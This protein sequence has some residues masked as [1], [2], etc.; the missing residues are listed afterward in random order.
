MGKQE[1]I[2]KITIKK[3]FS[4]LP[5][6]DVELAFEKFNKDIYSEEEKIKLTRDLLR[7]VFS[8]FTSKKLLNLKD[9]GS[10]WILKKHISTRER[11]PYSQD[12]YRRILKNLDKISVID[13][14]AGV[15]GFSYNFFKKDINYIGIEGIGQLV[16]LMNF[17]FN[18]QG[19]KGEAIHLSLFEL[20]K[21]KKIIKRTKKPRIVFLFKTLD[22]LEMLKRDY[23]KKL[24]L[25]I[26]PL[27]DKVVVSFATR[28]LLSKK[29]FRV[30]RN[31]IINFIENNFK[32]IDDFE[33]GGERYIIFNEA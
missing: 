3:E 24:L 33:L 16:D 29:P 9:K 25:G 15:N 26:V 32:I 12:L 17:Y 23:S 11:F 20:P 27:A 30:S 7:K 19:I 21:I 18:S 2:K 31:W 28:S 14:G 4:K 22:S 8:V 6:K 5:E 13:L 10:D 1:L